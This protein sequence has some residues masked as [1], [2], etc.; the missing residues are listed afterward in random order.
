MVKLS[1]LCS[2]VGL[3]CLAFA[4]GGCVDQ[5]KTVA[6][7]GIDIVRSSADYNRNGIDDYTDFVRGA[8]RDAQN[9]PRHD[10][11]Y[12]TGGYPAEDVGVCAD[13]VWRAFREAGY[14]LKDMV[15]AD[16][17]ANPTH[18]PRASQPDPN[19][20]FRRVKNLHVFFAKYAQQLTLDVGRIDQW[21]PGDIAIFANPDHIGIVSEKRGSKGVPYLIHNG[22]QKNR[23]ENFLGSPLATI[24]TSY[25]PI[26]HYR[27]EANK[28]DPDL[29]RPWTAN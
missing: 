22:G 5:E 28:I 16:I 15:D 10:G 29:L 27:F 14:S 2:L 7:F 13:V 20:D 18:Y 24:D 1:R 4:L 6:D 25:Q 26:G 3:L 9:Y 21:M 19:I 12:V 23:E 17:A 11:S 8:R